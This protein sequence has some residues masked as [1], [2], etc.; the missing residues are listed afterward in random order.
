M[1]YLP[2]ELFFPS[3]SLAHSS[4]II[5]L[6][7]DL[8]PERLQLAY[9]SGIFPWFEDGEPITWW[10]PNPRMVLFLD[11]L[12]VSKSMRNILN[13]N[14]LKVTFN[15]NFRDVISNCQEVKREGQNGTWI[16]NDMIEAY[17]KLHELGIAKSVEVWQDEELVG[18]LYG[19]DLGHVFCGESMFSLVSNASKVAFIALVEKLR[20]ENYKLL[21]CQVYN[22]HLESLGCREIDREEFIEILK[23]E[24]VDS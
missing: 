17:C 10:S 7:G 14:V 23:V 9:K 12:I 2:K 24:K 19:V 21:D 3:V 11:E 1:Y 6:G 5:A 15:Q 16:T 4:G 13:R 18:G 8:S 22:S 20:T